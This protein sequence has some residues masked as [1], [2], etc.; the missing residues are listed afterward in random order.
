[1][2]Y[3]VVLGIPFGESDCGSWSDCKLDSLYKN[4]LVLVLVHL[5]LWTIMH[6]ASWI[7]CEFM[8]FVGIEIM[9]ELKYFHWF[10]LEFSLV[11]SSYYD[12]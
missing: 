5:A 6:F 4:P 1:M 8:D 3:V 7:L 10:I 2:N 12:A 9:H 11:S